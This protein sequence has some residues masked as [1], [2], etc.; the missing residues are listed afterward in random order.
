MKIFGFVLALTILAAA[1]PARAERVDCDPARCAVQA[2]IAAECPCEA[3]INHGQ[4]VSCVAHIVRRFASDGTIPITCKGKVTRCAAK[5]TCGKAGFVTCQ[6]P[7]DTCTIAT[8]AVTGTCADD[9]TIVC[10]TD[11]DCG[12]TCKIKSSADRCAGLGGAVGTANT[13]CAACGG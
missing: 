4:Y 3:A 7:T 10:A 5:S 6:V 9:P 8:G 2:A 1:S 11:L 12:A 13:C